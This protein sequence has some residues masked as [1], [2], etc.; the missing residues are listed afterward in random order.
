M[1]AKITNEVDV[2]TELRHL[3]ELIAALDR[4]VEH[5]ERGGEV[6]IASDAAR[7]KENALRDAIGPD[8]Y[9]CRS[10]PSAT[11]RRVDKLRGPG[12]RAQP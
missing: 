4:R 7:L 1:S 10:P 2:A 9:Y 6:A 3:Q 12:C 8:G 11:T 5:V